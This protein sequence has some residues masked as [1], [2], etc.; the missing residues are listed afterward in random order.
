M[1]EELEKTVEENRS[2]RRGRFI[3]VLAFLVFAAAI[4]IP[5]GYCI[6]GYSIARNAAS[7][8]ICIEIDPKLRGYTY[9][10]QPCTDQHGIPAQINREEFERLQAWLLR[11]GIAPEPMDYFLALGTKLFH[12][13][14]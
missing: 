1:N 6:Y 5:V 13:L 7:D 2:R 8:G 3:E 4:M 10:I 9:T 12:R 11:G 14:N